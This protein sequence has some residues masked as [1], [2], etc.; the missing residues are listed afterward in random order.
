MIKINVKVVRDDD[1]LF[2]KSSTDITAES[3]E[4][5]VVL[6]AYYLSSR[7]KPFKDE[8]LQPFNACITK[9][10]DRLEANGYGLGHIV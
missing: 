3:A 2:V 10:L 7:V 8:D 4:L 6:L 9:E 5:A 1:D